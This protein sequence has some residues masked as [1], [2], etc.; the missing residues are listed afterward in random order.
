MLHLI[1]SLLRQSRSQLRSLSSSSS[2]V[3][4]SILGPPNAGKSTL[5]N[6]LLDKSQHYTLATARRKV[7][8][9]LTRSK[10]NG[11]AL[12]SPIPG[13]TRDRRQTQGRLGGVVFDLMDTA[14]IDETSS[15]NDPLHES[16]RQQTSE[17]A[18]QAD[19]VLLMVDGRVGLTADVYE[20]SRWLRQTAKGKIVVLANKMEG[21]QGWLDPEMSRLGFGE[22]LP[23]SALQGEGMADLAVL[24]HQ[25]AEEKGS[26]NEEDE[27]S[28]NA[29]K[30][31][32]MA[33]L[34]RPNV[35]KSTLVNALLKQ[36]R[37]IAGPTP[38]LTRDAIA[39][40]WE[41]NERPV[42][43]VD[44]AGIRRYASRDHSNEIEDMAVQDAIRAMK[45][46][47][48]A[49]LVLDAGER[50]LHRQELA[51][52]DTVL[53][54]GR[55]LVVAANK[56]DLI[57]ESGYDRADLEKGIREQ[58]EDRF[59][60]L[61]QTP[62]VPMCSLDEDSV[63]ELMPVVFNA[64]DRW[65]R[66][67]PTGQLNRWVS[68][69][70]RGQPAPMVNGRS[71]KIK[72]VLQTKGRPP[73][74]LL[75]CNVDTIP[76]SYVRYLRRNFQDTFEMFGMEVRMAVK[77][78]ATENP[79]DKHAKKRSG[80]GLGGKETRMRKLYSDLQRHGAPQKDRRRRRRRDN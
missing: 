31:L 56:M 62:I 65:N 6:R 24:I 40:A 23:I 15:N 72:Y 37:V 22:P 45:V 1:P 71:A 58:L 67:I 48:V 8:G 7:S 5:F 77:K 12:V 25:L 27:D 57:L 44:T 41:W 53:K 43:I 32:Q 11:A 36:E 55:S 51:I 4:V 52:A 73:T 3:V 21:N 78:S 28:T 9:R 76:D 49:V 50:M 75:F 17:A 59:P 20:T 42:Q 16:M 10:P 2:R 69:V 64:R 70:S 74:F 33:I 54:E 14:G 47:D 60:S 46:A 79:F 63:D 39:V 29:E 34:G 66:V 38:G 68:E 13:T 30:P 26:N 19:L 80:S 61:R 35:G 18:R